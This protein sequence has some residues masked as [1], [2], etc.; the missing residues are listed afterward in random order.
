MVL[1]NPILAASLVVARAA[2][3]TTSPMMEALSLSNI[4]LF[5]YLGKL[6][7]SSGNL[8]QWNLYKVLEILFPYVNAVEEH[9]WSPIPCTPSAFRSAFVNVS[10]SNSL[11]SILP[12]PK[13]CPMKD[14]HGY[15]GFLSLLG[16]ALAM[17]RFNT[18]A[19]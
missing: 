3:Q 6:V 2:W 1:G 11:A 5:L 12:I 8:Q 9:R 14:G 15:T 16:H 10:N 13:P 7:L 4:K 19:V 17:T 18:N